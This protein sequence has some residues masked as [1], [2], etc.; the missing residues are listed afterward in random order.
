MSEV[1]VGGRRLESIWEIRESD[2]LSALC[3]S[4]DGALLAVGTADGAVAVYAANDGQLCWR[5]TAH[6][7]GT[8]ALAWSADGQALA[9]GG[10]DTGVTLWA[11]ADGTEVRRLKT[12]K[13]WVSALAWSDANVL[14]SI[15]GRELKLWNAGGDLQYAFPAAKSTLTGLQWLSDGQLLTSCYGG[16]DRWRPGQSEP[17]RHYP[18][19]GSLSSLAVS[20]DEAIIAAACQESAIH[21]WLAQNGED[22]QMGGYPTKVQQMDWSQ[23]SRYFATGGGADLIIWDC[24]SNGPQGT[25]PD[26]VPVDRKQ[27]TALAFGYTGNQV[28]SGGEYG[29]VII[30]D[31]G[32]RKPIAH[33]NTNAAVS[34]LAWRHDDRFLA[35]GS[36][37]GDLRI[38]SPLS[39]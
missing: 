34:I 20:P 11:A 30:Y 25:I 8:V 3:W 5:K 13:G 31:A 4:P 24:G 10:H 32:T 18:W 2:Y 26:H 23:D 12:G 27:V 37:E 39:A 16:V 21:L 36:A 38:C 17:T 6:K 35:I 28:A 33:L 9:S 29:L 7:L 1:K 22:F 15:A 14:A 19:K